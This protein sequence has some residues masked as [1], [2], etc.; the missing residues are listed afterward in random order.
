MNRT[1]VRQKSKPRV[2]RSILMFVVITMFIGIV[3]VL[4]FFWL[5]FFD[6]QFIDTYGIDEALKYKN[7]YTLIFTLIGFI[8][9]GISIVVA[10]IFI[11]K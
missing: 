5:V 1:R 6:L 7:L 9:I 10:T 11:M 2:K 4:S 8:M 3:L